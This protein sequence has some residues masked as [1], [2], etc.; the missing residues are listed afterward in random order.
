MTPITYED[1]INYISAIRVFYPKAFPIS[2][3]PKEADKERAI[4][5]KMLFNILREYPK[6]VC[7]VA[8]E[9]LV[10]NFN[11]EYPKP[12]DIIAEIKKLQVAF[13]KSE[14]ELWSELTGVLKEVESCAYRFR[15][16][17]IE[18]NG[19]TQG[20]NARI[21][22]DEIFNGLSPE[23]KEYCRNSGGLIDLA[24]SE[25]LEYE[26]GRF[27]RTI[28]TLKERARTRRETGDHLA[29]LIYGMQALN[30]LDCADTKL[31]KEE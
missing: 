7:D 9:N 20:E 6:E 15:F 10:K 19:K 4:L 16:N 13:E 1:V 12:A 18:Y 27:M 29:G 25:G 5:I 26:K 31:L 24:R 28:P 8:V 17:A 11:Y 22:I 14:T 23:L 21:R 30:A 3:D 2:S